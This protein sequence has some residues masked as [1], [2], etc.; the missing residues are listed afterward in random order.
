MNRLIFSAVLAAGCASEGDTQAVDTGDVTTVAAVGS[1]LYLNS[2][3]QSEECKEY[4]GEGWTD[5]LLQDDC[6]APVPGAVGELVLDVGCDRTSF[7]GE[8]FIDPDTDQASTL[9]FPGVAGDSC[10]GLS[11]GCTFAGGEYVASELCDQPTGPGG[12]VAVFSPFVQVCTEP[13]AGESAGQSADGEVCTWQAISGSTEEGRQFSDYVDCSAVLTQRPYWAA[14]VA[15][16]TAADDP[17]LSDADWVA[18]YDWVT[19]QVEASACT[20]CHST[21]LAPDGAASG[22]YLEAEPIWTDTFDED[23]MA[24]MADWVSSVAFG[25]FPPEDNNGFSRDTTGVPTTDPDRMLAFFEGEL[26]GRGLTQADFSETPPFGGPLYD[27]LVYEAGACSGSNGIS[28]DGTIT[29]S[30]G[31]AR[32][33]YI[34][35][36]TSMAPGVPPNLDMPEGT[37]WRVDVAPTADPVTTG[38]SYGVVP[39]G[40]TQ[41]YPQSGAPMAL[42]SGETY[43]LYA[44]ADVYQ[45][46]TRCLFTAP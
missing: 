7:L 39:D 44:L 34:M 6:A 25:A 22:W 30:G 27:Q 2:F 14:T 46:V 45:P 23:G 10:D 40:A 32:Y 11:I 41:A 17:R 37:L 1:C 13:L 26:A 18:E 42:D 21:A 36:E 33:V 12:S 9:V 3:S 35:G 24:M 16:D 29:W 19:E 31:G 8:C 28:A 5:E 38:I 20:C 4:L 15:N 43:Y